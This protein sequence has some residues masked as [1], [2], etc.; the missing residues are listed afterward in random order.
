MSSTIIA[1]VNFADSSLILIVQ[2]KQI[3]E[4]RI[5]SG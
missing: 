2:R 3:V 1:R 5:D 4:S